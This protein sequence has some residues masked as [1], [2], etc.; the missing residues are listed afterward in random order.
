MNEEKKE[1]SD[2]ELIKRLLITQLVMNGASIRDIMKITGM[3]S[4]SIYKFLPKN[5][6]KTKDVK[7]N[8]KR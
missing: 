5:L 7:K 1:T 2:L 8:G 6:V 4:S 3:G